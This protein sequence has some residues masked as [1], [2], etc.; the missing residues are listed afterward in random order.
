[1]EAGRVCDHAAMRRPCP[2]GE[3]STPNG[4]LVRDRIGRSALALLLV[5]GGTAVAPASAGAR[6]SVAR[7]QAL[8]LFLSSHRV[9]SAPGGRYIGTVLGER[10]IT[11][12]STTLPVLARRVGADGREWLKVLLPGRPN[13]STGWIAA[14]ATLART[15][16]WHLL[17][18]TA[19]R[20]V[21]AYRA[22][23]VIRVFPTIVGKPSTPTPH[24]Q[25]FVEENVRMPAGS[26]GA[27]F[28]L[29]LSA[30]SNVL[31]EFEGGPGQIAL[32]GLVGV[33]GTLGTAVSHGCIRL[34]NPTI[35]WLAARI[36]PGVPVT[37]TS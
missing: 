5:I 2:D 32:H 15:T 34:A 19:S 11:G 14:T 23:R 7:T 29:A 27:P 6:P 3:A 20:R 30:R 17:V 36:R 16:D 13:S 12:Q 28:A 10:P 35:R 37:I 25:F 4:S 9:L 33:G 26:A 21:F 31:Q 8:A 1:M 22:G 18:R 24:G